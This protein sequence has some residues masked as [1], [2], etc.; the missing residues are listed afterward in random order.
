MNTRLL[1]I[2]LA[3]VAILLV[4]YYFWSQSNQSKK[5]LSLNPYTS[6]N[7][8][9]LTYPVSPDKIGVR[10]ITIV[11]DFF[12]KV[13]RLEKVGENTKIILDNSDAQTP[14]FITG[15]YTVYFRTSGKQNVAP[16]TATI[17]DIKLDTYVDLSMIYYPKTN[18]WELRGVSIQSNP[19]SLPTAS[20][21]K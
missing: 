15:G 20:P 10:S 3:V 13:S 6:T 2:L 21:A 1:I 5:S 12:G 4:G 8:I 16:E 7:P 17:N 9:P 14:E 19:P 18:N 11:Y